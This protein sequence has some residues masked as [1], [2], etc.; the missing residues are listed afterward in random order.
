M[1]LGGGRGP[2]QDFVERD[3]A[4]EEQIVDGRTARLRVGIEVTLGGVKAEAEA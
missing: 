3:P 1:R 4:Q 2:L